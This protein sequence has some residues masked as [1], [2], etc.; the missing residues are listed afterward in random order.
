MCTN[1]NSHILQV[2]NGTKK[3][4][5]SFLIKLNLHLPKYS[6]N[7][8]AK[9]CTL[10]VVAVLFITVLNWKHSL[11]SILGEWVNYLWDAT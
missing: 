11:K 5:E 6:R 8:H 10:M 2:L 3:E 4:F 7:V 9:T 1:W